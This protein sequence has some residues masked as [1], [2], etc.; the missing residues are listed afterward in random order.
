MYVVDIKYM[1]LLNIITKVNKKGQEL[2]KTKI[3]VIQFL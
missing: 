1:L 2:K 3:I